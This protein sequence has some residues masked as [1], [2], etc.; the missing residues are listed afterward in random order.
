M[1]FQRIGG[2]IAKVVFMLILIVALLI[3]GMIW[4]DFLG[5]IDFKAQ[6]TPLMSLVGLGEPKPV[7]QPYT[8][9]LLDDDRLA[10]ERQAIT[11]GWE[12]LE[13]AREELTLREAELKQKESE[14]AEREK[15]VEEKQNSLSEAIHQYDN[16]VANL[17]QTAQYMMGMPPP[18]AVAIMEQ[19]GI[20]DLVDL[21][22]TSERLSQEAGEASL[23]AYW[24]SIMPNRVRAAEIQRLL[25]EKPNLNLND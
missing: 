10:K 23:V 25:V 4:L 8:P 7:E 20:N 16:K 22:R 11:I 15:S 18:D 14:I 3:G 6:L 2:I 5:F 1:T 24:L 17:E 13:Q 19:Y 9:T 12:E 21:L